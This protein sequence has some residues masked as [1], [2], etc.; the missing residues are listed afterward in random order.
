M[1]LNLAYPEYSGIKFKLTQFPD[2]QQDITLVTE[3]QEEYEAHRG[4][5]GTQTRRLSV[6]P[7][8]EIKSRFN[9][10]K[11]L[12]KIVCATKALRAFGWETIYLTIPY[13]LG[14]RSDRRFVKGG[15]SYLVEVIAPI[16]NDLDFK[17]VKT[18]DVH[19]DVAAACINNLEVVT[20]DKL[21]EFALS[22]L[23]YKKNKSEFTLISPDGGALKKI[24]K[25][26]EVLNKNHFT[27]PI[28]VICCSKY[29]DT[30]G[31][32]SRVNVPINYEQHSGKDLI[33]IDDICDGGRTFI[34]IVKEIKLHENV[35]VNSNDVKFNP[36]IYLIVSHGIFSAGFK[37][38][39][40][41]FDGIF[42]TNS[43]KDLGEAYFDGDKVF[44]HKVKQLNVFE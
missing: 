6:T 41:Y 14:S 30:D 28:D 8:V 15:T 24:Y 34:N 19:S 21:I 32:L 11:D 16:I 35:S 40:K 18:F 23:K 31:K 36:K 20:N 25:N 38:L 1:I 26:V 2:G 12:E 37:E 29:R 44:A 42:T 9:S 17:R 43:I 39:S 7:F 4:I 22:E 33:I 5:W 3:W 10:F 13:L 27:N